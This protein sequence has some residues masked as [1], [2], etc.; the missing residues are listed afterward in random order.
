MTI[1]KIVDWKIVWAE[2]AQYIESEFEPTDPVVFNSETWKIELD[3]PADLVGKRISINWEISDSTIW[4]DEIIKWVLGND[5]E[6]ILKIPGVKETIANAEKNIT[7]TPEEKEVDI[8]EAQEILLS[9]QYI[10]NI[11]TKDKKKVANIVKNISWDFLEL[12]EDR[13]DRGFNSLEE[14]EKYANTFNS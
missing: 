4:F 11:T 14:A 6:R 7:E 13:W 10:V 3:I 9:G 12:D 2:K 8:Q 5:S 1:F